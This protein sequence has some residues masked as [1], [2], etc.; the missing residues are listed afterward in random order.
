MTAADSACLL[1]RVVQKTLILAH[2]KILVSIGD[3]SD[4]LVDGTG[5]LILKMRPSFQNSRK[6]FLGIDN[7]ALSGYYINIVI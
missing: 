5:S 3:V 7:S 1:F 4:P 2:D 6:A